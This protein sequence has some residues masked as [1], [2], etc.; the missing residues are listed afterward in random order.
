MSKRINAFPT[1]TDSGYDLD[2][3]S[4]WDWFAG[5]S[6]ASIDVYMK[7]NPEASWRECADWCANMADWMIHLSMKGRANN[8]A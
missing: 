8:E 1:A 5:Q 3:M 2:G 7:Y 6:M 4:L